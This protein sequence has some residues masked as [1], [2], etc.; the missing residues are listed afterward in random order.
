[1]KNQGRILGTEEGIQR[2]KNAVTLCMETEG[3]WQSEKE[4]EE[5]G[6]VIHQI[7]EKAM[8]S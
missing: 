8:H 5:G 3:A 6:R 2:I 7:L 1:M 4:R